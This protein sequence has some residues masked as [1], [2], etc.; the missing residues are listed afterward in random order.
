MLN[1]DLIDHAKPGATWDRDY[2]V[3]EELWAAIPP[4]GYDLPGAGWALGGHA[5][6]LVLLGLWLVGLVVAVPV[7]VARMPLDPR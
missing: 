4:F 7:A 2:A 6:A 3:G 1:Q 5:T